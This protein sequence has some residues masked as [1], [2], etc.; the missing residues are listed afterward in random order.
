MSCDGEIWSEAPG[1]ASPDSNSASPA[2]TTSGP[3]QTGTQRPRQGWAGKHGRGQKAGRV[4]RD[5]TAESGQV[6]KVGL[7]SRNHTA[8]TN[9]VETGQAKDGLP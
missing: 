7:I 1:L 8:G 9:S 5:Q 3:V 6:Q 4:P 2:E